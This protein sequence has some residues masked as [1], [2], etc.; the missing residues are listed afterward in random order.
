MMMYNTQNYW[1][2]GLCPSSGWLL[3]LEF[4][5]LSTHCMQITITLHRGQC[6]ENSI[7][8]HMR[9]ETDPVSETSCFSSNYLE[10]G[11]WTKSQNPV[12]LSVYCVGPGVRL[13]NITLSTAENDYVWR[14]NYI[15]P[16]VEEMTLLVLRSTWNPVSLMSRLA[17]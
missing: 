14:T 1:V 16:N 3:F 11:R 4:L 6:M 10:S 7:S 9:T 12:I 2:F 13:F 8:P 5:P 17:D 15:G